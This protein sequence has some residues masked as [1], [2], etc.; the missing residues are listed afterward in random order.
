[1]AGLDNIVF[2]S[3]QVFLGAGGVWKSSVERAGFIPVLKADVGRLEAS[4]Q[5]VVERR[6]GLIGGSAGAAA[7]ESSGSGE[8][9]AAAGSGA[10]GPQKGVTAGG[11]SSIRG[12]SSSA[13]SV[14]KPITEFSQESLAQKEQRTVAIS[15]LKANIRKSAID[16]LLREA[17]HF[18]MSRL[19]LASSDTPESNTIEAWSNVTSPALENQD[20][21][22]R[23]SDEWKAFPQVIAFL[24]RLMAA[25]DSPKVHYEADVKK[26]IDDN[27][28]QVPDPSAEDIARFDS[29]LAK[30]KRDVS[31]PAEVIPD[32]GAFQ[33]NIDMSTLSDIPPEDLEQLCRDIKEFRLR[34]VMIEREN[35]RR[36]ALSENERQRAHKMKMVEQSKASHEEGKPKPSTGNIAGQDTHD[37]DQQKVGSQASE[38]DMLRDSEKRYKDQLRKSSTVVEPSLKRGISELHDAD[39][40]DERL[41]KQRNISKKEVARSGNNTANDHR[42]TFKELE[43]PKDKGYR[44]TVGDVV[45]FPGQNGIY[46]GQDVD[47]ITSVESQPGVSSAEA[48]SINIKIDFNKRT[49]KEAS[50]SFVESTE[51]GTKDDTNVEIS[52]NSNGHVAEDILPFTSEELAERLSRLRK[53]K[54]VDELVN[55]Y[56]GVYEDELVDYIF[57]NIS[58]NKSK[59]VLLAD[60]KETFDDDAIIMADKIWQTPELRS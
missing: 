55:E 43:K 29:I 27:K 18:A 7:S 35:A 14:W 57:E 23:F 6:N 34:V 24:E 52:E 45:G 16:T 36:E 22:I 12:A 42:R 13:V 19:S 54:F 47:N 51:S 37:D 46:A 50:V 59:V 26:H 11:S 58:E 38:Q 17:V 31:D 10:N 48:G 28:G 40:N 44:D 33:Y 15:G 41:T 39:E 9:V 30:A 49:E 56:L 8:G 21:F 53:S 5:Q 32:E 20:I 25:G 3:P 4:L 60:L 1:M 2:V